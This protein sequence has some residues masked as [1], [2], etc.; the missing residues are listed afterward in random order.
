MP[1]E[2]EYTP[3]Q[4]RILTYLEGRKNPT[5]AHTLA[6]YLGITPTPSNID[7]LR[8]EIRE[9]IRDGLVKSYTIRRGGT[10]TEAYHL[11]GK[12]KSFKGKIQGHGKL[13][14]LLNRWFGLILLLFGL[15]FLAYQDFALTG[16]L[17]SNQNFITSD[18]GFVFALA[19]EIFGG[20]F[21]IK[22][23]K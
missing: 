16:N 7:N 22:S 11:K 2:R 20:F 14:R 5:E 1:T 8:G 17:I 15:S 4:E 3:R 9:L 19:L 18:S 13:E 6:G 23:F 21:L 12:G 10:R